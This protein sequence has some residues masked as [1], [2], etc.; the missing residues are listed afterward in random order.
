[1]KRICLTIA[2]LI[3]STIFSE[4]SMNQENNVAQYDM[5]LSK[6]DSKVEDSKVSEETKN[7]DPISY[8]YSKAGTSFLIQNFGVGR[9]FHNIQKYNGH[10]LNFNFHLILMGA[11]GKNGVFL[12][13]LKYEYLKY[14]K[15][16]CSYFGIGAEVGSIFQWRGRFYGVYPNIELIFGKERKKVQFTQLSINLLPAIATA[17][18]IVS[19]SSHH[20][21]LGH[22]DLGVVV[23]G[24]LTTVEYTIG[25]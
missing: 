5:T 16:N 15:D 4:E 22:A 9:R 19:I 6:E 21:F 24:L 18:G 1:M 2:T 10:D 3:I 11:G 12:P 7:N 17:V 14:K 20:P 25:F 8:W 23:F 13:S